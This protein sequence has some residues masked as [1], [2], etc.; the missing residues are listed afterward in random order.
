MRGAV[1]AH[2]GDLG[3][4]PDRDR[5]QEGYEQVTQVH[6]ESDAQASNDWPGWIR[7]TTAGSK[8]RCPAI[9]RRASEAFSTVTKLSQ[10][11]RWHNRVR[12]WRI[13]R[14]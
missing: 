2:R 8:D 12:R 4:R 7:T 9:R 11:A 5:E 1:R 13:E 6:A 10:A 14:T 3:A